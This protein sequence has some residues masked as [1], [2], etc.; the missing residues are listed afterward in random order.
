ML[1]LAKSPQS[2]QATGAIP[3]WVNDWA[4]RRRPARPGKRDE[5]DKPRASLTVASEVVAEERDE[6]AEA[7]AAQQRDRLKAQR[8]QAIL[9]GLDELDRWIED[10]LS[11]GLAGFVAAAPQQ[12]RALAQRMVDAKAPGL[13][14]W[15]DALPSDILTLP[16]RLRSDAVIEALGS[17]H[18]LA[19]A[20][21]RQD[22]LPETL[23]HDVRRLVGWAQERQALLDD[24]SALRVKAEWTVIA[25]HVEVQPD[26]LRRFET[27]LMGVHAD[28][29]VYA[30][31]IDFMPVATAAGGS[32]F[33]PGEKFSA[34]LVFYP[35]AAPLRAILAERGD[36]PSAASV[37]AASLDAALDG[38]DDLRGAQ[39]WLRQWPMTVSG[40]TCRSYGADGLWLVN[41][42]AGVPITPRQQDE[43]R[44]LTGVSLLS[45]TGLWD[46]RF[47]MPVMADTALGRWVRQ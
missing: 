46:G 1:L 26:K 17:I 8:E 19:A 29:P 16:E 38:F 12:C 37:A 11:R 25:T 10:R 42:K 33:L 21:R 7:R 18:L 5:D 2:F 45:V 15:I 39:P 23:R 43:G 32:P 14:T 20:Y 31:L 13:A 3:D 6:K 44:V 27:W 36:V 22:Q 41:G 30:V 40:V 4:G 28:V 34:E 24:S 47:F 35:S 9:A